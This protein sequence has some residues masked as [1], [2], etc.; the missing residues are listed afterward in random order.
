M[1]W[2][3]L[4]WVSCMHTVLFW[5]FDWCS[6]NPSIYRISAYVTSINE[7][8]LF[9]PFWTWIQMI[10]IVFCV[11]HAFNICDIILSHCVTSQI[12]LLQ[13]CPVLLSR[14]A[15]TEWQHHVTKAKVD[16]QKCAIATRHCDRQ[17]L[18]RVGFWSCFPKSPNPGPEFS[19][20]L[21]TA[22]RHYFYV[23]FRFLWWLET[24]HVADTR[25]GAPPP[26][27]T[28]WWVPPPLSTNSASAPACYGQTTLPWESSPFGEKKYHRYS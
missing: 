10:Y 25:L 4:H 23:Y 8:L 20:I 1:N 11:C 13:V 3:V 22:Y 12:C 5:C 16:R 26:P 14:W 19:K 18:A 28:I 6:P 7:S 17:L 2:I 21:C 9:I 27:S 24:N 15:L